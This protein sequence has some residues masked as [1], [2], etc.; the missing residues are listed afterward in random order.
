MTFIKILMRNALAV[1]PCPPTLYEM[2]WK[3]N[4]DNNNNE[5]E[6]SEET[7]NSMFIYS[8][9]INSR[10]WGCVS[11]WFACLPA[12][13]SKD[14]AAI[15]ENKWWHYSDLMFALIASISND[16]EVVAIHT[17]THTHAQSCWLLFWL[18]DWFGLSFNFM[19]SGFHLKNEKSTRQKL[20]YNWEYF[21]AHCAQAV[22]TP[23]TM[24]QL[25]SSARINV[26]NNKSTNINTNSS[27]STQILGVNTERHSTT[28]TPTSTPPTAR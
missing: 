19:V 12:I 6:K 28:P 23:K 21:T 18:V 11:S 10:V 8:Y 3:Q 2:E 22:L 4:N 1:L 9:V 20:D 17:H 26:H 5:Q 7:N 27:N 24:Q 16:V 14:V 25:F 15:I 13:R